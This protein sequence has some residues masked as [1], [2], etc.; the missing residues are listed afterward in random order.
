MTLTDVAEKSVAVEYQ[1]LTLTSEICPHCPAILPE[2][3][4]CP[5]SCRCLQDK[6]YT[7]L[8][9]VSSLSY[10]WANPR[11]YDQKR[12]IDKQGSGLI[13]HF[14]YMAESQEGIHH[15]RMWT[16]PY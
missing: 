3:I 8:D 13:Q 16:R 5:S 10:R 9:P 1:A 11:K 4:S 2:M 15:C 12:A 7:D 6:Q 14:L